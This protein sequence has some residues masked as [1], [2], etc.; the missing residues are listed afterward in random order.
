MKGTNEK[1]NVYQQVDRQ[2]AA[3]DCEKK[4]MSWKMIQKW[5][6]DFKSLS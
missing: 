4:G 1:R 6:Y 5:D 2:N 3:V